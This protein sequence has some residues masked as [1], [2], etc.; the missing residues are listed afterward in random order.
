MLS[1]LN[2]FFL[3]CILILREYWNVDVAVSI[4]L[5]A[6]SNSMCFNAILIGHNYVFSIFDTFV[7]IVDRYFLL[8]LKEH[9]LSHTFVF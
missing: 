1:L 4:L 8:L 2:F 6:I 7:I 9:T 3:L 5:P